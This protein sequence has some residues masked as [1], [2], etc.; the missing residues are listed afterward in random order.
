M[1]KEC[2]MF[3]FRWA[4]FGAIR[5]ITCRPFLKLFTLDFFVMNSSLLA[6]LIRNNTHTN[7]TIVVSTEQNKLLSYFD[8]EKPTLKGRTWKIF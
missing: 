5:L 8:F 1:Y 2:P 6:T 3:M 7:N 4:M